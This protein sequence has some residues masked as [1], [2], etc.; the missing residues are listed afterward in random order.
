MSDNYYHDNDDYDDEHTD[1]NTLPVF[2][3]F[4]ML[5]LALVLLLGRSL[6]NRPKLNSILSEPAMILIVSVF[7]SFL[8]KL[9]FVS[10]S[11]EDDSNNNNNANNNNNNNNYG[12][13]DQNQLS[14]FLLT[15]SGEIFFMVFLPPIMF[16]S[17]YELKRELFFRHLKPIVSFA[18]VGTAVSGVVTGLSM[19]GISSL[20][21][22]GDVDMNLLELLTFGSLITATDTVSVLGVLNAKKVNPHLFSLVF[23]ESAL[24]DA[25]AIVLFQSFS[26]LVRLGGIENQQSLVKE[27]TS[28]VTVFLLDILGCPIMGMIF[29][30]ASALIFKHVDFHGTPILELSLYI[31]IMYFPFIVA[32]VLGMS[33]I[34]TIFFTGIFAR[35][36]IEPNV[37]DETKHNA[38]VIFNLVAY[39]AEACIFINLGLSVF[40]FQ[41][42]F[43]W[44]FIGFAFLASLIGRAMS[45][46]PISFF[47]NLSLVV[48]KER[49]LSPLMNRR[50]TVDVATSKDVGYDIM[51]AIS[52]MNEEEETAAAAAAAAAVTHNSSVGNHIKYIE[53]DENSVGTGIIRQRHTPDKSL[54]KVIPAKFM[55]FLWFA[56][57]RGAVA[58]AC[59]RDFPDVYGNK[60]D[61]I[62]T[63]M[64]IVFFSVI[65][66]GAFCDPLLKIL[67]I[68]MGVDNQEY[69]KEWRNRRSLDG[70]IHQL[71]MYL[72][73]NKVRI[74]FSKEIERKREIH[75]HDF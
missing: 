21:W 20:G 5:L 53:E 33:G 37:S 42:S 67:N 32:E 63:T 26:R 68:Q 38:E 35:R 16:N 74:R 55:H 54:D 56:G 44:A 60:D 14:K 49:P 43:H 12:G 9:F 4:F 34:V 11:G 36:Y 40:G 1:H 52:T 71:G 6:H 61:V 41:G 10:S 50:A 58:Y 17:G 64:V 72:Y 7:F 66:M 19:Y 25:V 15:F 31:L 62:A 3:L 8:I 75:I 39:L 73:F 13:V 24:N 18:V 47:F 59:A 48:Y 65:V 30:F 57:L 46:Y 27:V 2:F 23:G 70:R 29:A 22:M 45:I 69:M 28:F 51:A